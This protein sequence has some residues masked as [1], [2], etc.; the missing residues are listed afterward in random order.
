MNELTAVGAPGLESLLALELTELGLRKPKLFLA[1]SNAAGRMAFDGGMEEMMRANLLLRSADRV[2]VRLGS[3]SAADFGELERGA[4]KLPWEKY[5]VPGRTV[6]VKASSRKSKLYHE[7]GIEERVAKGAGQKVP[8]VAAGRG[9]DAQ[10]VVVTVEN[11]VVT[12]DMDSSGEPLSRRGYRLAQGKAPMKETLAAALLIASRWDTRAT[13][14]D[15]L[16]GS[17]T[18]AIEGA[19]MAMRFAPGG[20]R[21]FAFEEWPGFD[22]DAWRRVKAGARGTPVTPFPKILASD[23]DAGAIEAARANAERAGVLDRIEF[24]VKAVSSVTVPPGPGWLVTNPPYGVRVS[25]GKDL[26]DLYAQFGKVARNL[27]RDWTTT[28]VTSEPVL[29]R[30]TGL[31]FD[32][33]LP[34]MNGG[35][36]VRLYSARS[37]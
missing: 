6:S 8:R 32:E 28:I 2:L 12:V 17:G 7:G 27:G 21:K 22:A 14:L 10:S 30:A 9:D 1:N 3:F 23:R 37:A 13:L 29:A 26:R 15:P 36:D 16:C 25:E 33:G 31:S 24:S 19:L 18:I 35:L 5:L 11:D 34:T 20:A 4:A